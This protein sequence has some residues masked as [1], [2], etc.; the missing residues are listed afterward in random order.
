[1]LTLQVNNIYTFI[2]GDISSEHITGIDS[3]LKFRPQG[4]QF[5]PQFNKKYYKC[6]SCD[7]TTVVH[8]CPDCGSE[9]RFIRRQ[10]DGWK[11]QFW[12]NK[13]STYFPTGLMSLVVDYLTSNKVEFR[14]FDARLKPVQ[15]LNITTSPDVQYRDYQSIEVIAK[16]AKATRGIIQAATGSGKTLCC[17]GIMAELKV[18]PIIFFVTSIDLLTQAKECFEKALLIDGLPA[19]IGQIGGGII[20]IQNINV[21]TIQTAVRA[22]DKQWDK[23]TKFDENDTDDDT[24]I[25]EHKEEIRELIRTAKLALSDEVQHWKASTCLLVA[26][27][28]TSAYYTFGCS[29]TPW[30]DCGDDVLIQSCFGKT[31]VSISA[32][33]LIKEGW[34]MKP[35][36]K[37]I[38]VKNKVSKFK[39]WASI[40]K[41]QITDNHEYNNMVAKIA[42]AYI[43]NKRQVLVLINQINHG[44]ELSKLIP[45]SVFLSGNSPKAKR[46]AAIKNARNKYISCIISSV[47][48]DEGVD[49]RSLDTVILAGQGKS[50]VRAIQRIGR[51]LRTF[52]GKTKATAIDFYIH[53]KYLSD[54]AKARLKMYS[55]EPEFGIEHI[56]LKNEKY[57]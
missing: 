10:W 7:K 21:M 39:T 56:D 19:K 46:E 49:I 47:I 23:E 1:M 45:G 55:T 48:F 43:N 51:I 32:S 5:S 54:H 31:I 35:E 22:L 57:C 33:R 41:E 6:N 38:H 4:Y 42:N 25:A 36:I 30:R 20:D 44:K 37:V 14:R 53:Q 26:R 50:P 40:Y 8:M 27:E 2:I 12:N 29:A 17:A 28:L 34:L 11:H 9:C 18:C 16:A 13:T 3:V 52:D 24:P 15:N